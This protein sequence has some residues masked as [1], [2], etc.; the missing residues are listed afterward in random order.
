MEINKGDVTFTESRR[1]LFMGAGLGLVLVVLAIAAFSSGKATGVTG[2]GVVFLIGAAWLFASAWSN[3]NAGDK[4]L[5]VLKEDGI[6]FFN[7]DRMLPYTSIEGIEI[8]TYCTH[9]DI[10]FNSTF[11]ITPEKIETVPTFQY[12][13]SD[14]VLNKPGATKGRAFRKH[15]VVFRYGRLRDADGK[16]VDMDDLAEELNYRINRAYEAEAAILVPTSAANDPLSPVQ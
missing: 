14:S 5:M 7:A 9:K 4:P 1:V 3:R 8:E 10:Q 16:L 6:W 11:H 13:R 2:L 12:G 15:I